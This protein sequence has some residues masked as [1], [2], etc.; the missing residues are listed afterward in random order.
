MRPKRQR[1]QN[2]RQGFYEE[3]ENDQY[4]IMESVNSHSTPKPEKPSRSRSKKSLTSLND[5]HVYSNLPPRRGKRGQNRSAIPQQDQWTTNTWPRKDLMLENISQR[6]TAPKRLK[7]KTL[8]KRSTYTLGKDNQTWPRRS[9]IKS[10]PSAPKRKRASGKKKNTFDQAENMELSVNNILQEADVLFGSESRFIDEDSIDKNNTNYSSGNLQSQ[11]GL[12]TKRNKAKPI[13]NILS[14]AD[15]LFGMESRFIDEDNAEVWNDNLRSGT[16]LKELNISQPVLTAESNILYEPK[17]TNRTN[18]IATSAPRRRNCSGS[19][20]RHTPLKSSGKDD[21]TWPRMTKHQPSAPRRRQKSDRR[22]HSHGKIKTEESFSRLEKP[23][24]ELPIVPSTTPD[25]TVHNISAGADSIQAGLDHILEILATLPHEETSTN[26]YSGNEKSRDALINREI[27]NPDDA[28]SLAEN[29]YAEIK[30]FQKK[31]PPPRPPPPIYAPASSSSYSYIYTA[32]RRKKRAHNAASPERPPRNYCTIRPHR[33][34][35]RDRSKTTIPIQTNNAQI[36]ESSTNTN[37][38][39]S[40]SGTSNDK[41]ENDSQAQKNVLDSETAAQVQDFR[42][43]MNPFLSRPLPPPPRVKRS[44]SPPQKPP[45][46]RNSSLQRRK[47]LQNENS[48]IKE[49]VECSAVQASQVPQAESNVAPSNE[50]EPIE[51]PIKVEEASVGIQTDPPLDDDLDVIEEDGSETKDEC[52]QD[53]NWQINSS[54][55]EVLPEVSPLEQE[56]EMMKNSQE[57]DCSKDSG[58]GQCGDVINCA[59][60]IQNTSHENKT[61]E[62]AKESNEKEKPKLDG[63]CR[64]CQKEDD[65]S[66]QDSSK[67]PVNFQHPIPQIRLDFPSRLQLSELDVERLN[68]REVVADRLTV[69]QVDTTTLEV[70]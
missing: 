63:R 37:R 9:I 10:P 69:S 68:V 15:T 64:K 25:S 43:R 5:D 66:M 3:P 6:P 53:E 55:P 35:R 50:Y 32:P 39:H 22:D 11:N 31:T 19:L 51:D 4:N 46:S 7:Q 70:N 61:Q 26:L 52:Q 13:N 65:D 28:E 41:E 38:R 12:S 23:S 27:K 54:T 40:F 33:P 18:P 1:Y 29:P 34:P 14:E 56:A 30:Q 36:E 44:R 2:R 42:F 60:P 57:L 24:R 59:L 49:N 20:K 48:E 45:R 8:P 62:C 67:I 47:S 21:A 58:S 16:A 17:I